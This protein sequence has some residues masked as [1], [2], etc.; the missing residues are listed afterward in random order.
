MDQTIPSGMYRTPV[1]SKQ[2]RERTSHAKKFR[3]ECSFVTNQRRSWHMPP[4]ITA[5]AAWLSTLLIVFVFW[6]PLA[7]ALF[8]LFPLLLIP[9]FIAGVFLALTALVT[10]KHNWRRTVVVM[11]LLSLGGALYASNLGLAWGRLILFQIRKP[12]Y[13]R[14]LARAE[15]QGRVPDHLGATDDGPP[16]L[17]GLYWQRGLL[18]NYSLVVYDP[19]GRVAEI[20]T[21][22]DWQA[23]HSSDLSTLFGGTYYKCQDVG[24]GWYICWFT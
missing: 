20:N 21:M 7:D 1:E 12:G 19:S 15:Q 9:L 4:L 8:V 11:G 23:I 3:E 5:A 14:Q 24:G 10:V 18:D 13:V 17:H 6:A 22:H 16:T 2:G